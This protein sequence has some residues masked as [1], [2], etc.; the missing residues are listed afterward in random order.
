MELQALATRKITAYRTYRNLHKKLS[1]CTSLQ[2]C[3]QLSGQLIDAYEDNRMIWQELEYYQK[4]HVIL[5]K[6][7]AFAEFNRR[8][9][10]NSMSVKQLMKRKKQVEGNIW[11]AKSEMA[12][13]N[14]PHLDA[15]RQARLMGYQSELN[16]INRLLEDE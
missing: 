6:H 14:K 13:G 3:A 8:K 9:A 15:V 1:G 10:L 2:Q 5:G 11:R 16:D 4:H 12:K 7:P